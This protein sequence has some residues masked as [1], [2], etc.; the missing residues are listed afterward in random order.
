M[1]REAILD[2]TIL[3]VCAKCSYSLERCTYA[4]DCESMAFYCLPCFAVGWPRWRKAGSNTYQVVDS[5]ERKVLCKDYEKVGEIAEEWSLREELLLMEG[6]QHCGFGN[7]S[8][9]AAKIGSKSRE[10]CEHHYLRFW[11]R[12]RSKLPQIKEALEKCSQD[13]YKNIDM[14]TLSDDLF[15]ISDPQE[16]KKESELIKIGLTKSKIDKYRAK[17]SLL[18]KTSKRSLSLKDERGCIPGQYVDVMGF[19]PLR[20]DFDNEHDNDAE[21]FIADM[22]FEGTLYM[23][24]E[25]DSEKE[26]Q[27]KK[28]ILELYNRRLDE[29]VKRKSFVIDHGIL[30]IE[31]QLT[32]EKA[33]KEE[34]SI[35][36]KLMPYERFH[37]VKEHD[38][39]I[40]NIMKIRELRRRI[41]N[42]EEL[43]EYTSFEDIEVKDCIIRNI[44]LE[45]E[46]WLARTQGPSELWARYW[47][48]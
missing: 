1:L 20:R 37:S 3:L 29:R 41:G 44:C 31:R 8:D 27:L 24:P 11:W 38:D 45:K 48:P 7:W 2:H 32:L 21:N 23:M 26:V 39:L 40:D 46:K 33:S 35:R 42:L 17:I 30:E 9:V 16:Q 10:Q 13:C 12:N 5:L 28:E 34:K 6:L 18:Q 14:K 4:R 47:E 36:R 22:E 19:Y 43:G 25:N 15:S